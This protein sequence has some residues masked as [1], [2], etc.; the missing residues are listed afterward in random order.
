MRHGYFGKKLSRTK[1][2]RRQLFV[3]LVR[4][5]IKYGS[6][7]TTLAKA[8]AVQPLAE[9]LITKAKKNNYRKLFQELGD[10]NTARKLLADAQTRFA[11]R[12]SGFTKIIKLGTRAGDATEAVLFQFVD[13]PV[14]TTVIAPK[15]EVVATKSVPKKKTKKTKKT[16]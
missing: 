3:G 13:K 14:E 10:K 1:N 4:E 11:N 15:K 9:K 8:K 5:L 12:T 6:I 2:E 16:K 7:Q